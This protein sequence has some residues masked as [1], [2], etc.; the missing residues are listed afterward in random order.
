MLAN[1]QI[2]IK[3][4]ICYLLKNK[5]IYIKYTNG[6]GNN[7]FQ[8]YFCFL[9]VKDKNIKIINKFSIYRNM[10]NLTNRIL[11]LIYN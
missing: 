8:Y 4:V 11:S 2:D 3:K 10:Y 7:L 1:F 9:L 6:T 5:Y